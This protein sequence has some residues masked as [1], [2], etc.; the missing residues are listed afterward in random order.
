M[1]LGVFHVAGYG[2]A[3]TSNLPA[4]NCRTQMV[5]VV[6]TQNVIDACLQHDVKALGITEIIRM[7]YQKRSHVNFLESKF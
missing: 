4:F 5:N 1:S 2:L 6:G 7:S 3:G